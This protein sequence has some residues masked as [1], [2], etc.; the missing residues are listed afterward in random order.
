MTEP[1]IGGASAEQALLE[2]IGHP[3]GTLAVLAIY[4]LLFV[5]GWAVLYF[6]AFLPRGAPDLAPDQNEAH[7]VHQHGGTP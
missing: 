1:D 5:V 2:E 4:M 7:A 6:G 3:K